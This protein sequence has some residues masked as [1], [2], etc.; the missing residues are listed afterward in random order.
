M[1]SVLSGMRC[2]EWMLAVHQVL[3]ASVD[4]CRLNWFP[5]EGFT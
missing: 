2:G 5:P 4:S 3:P 1:A